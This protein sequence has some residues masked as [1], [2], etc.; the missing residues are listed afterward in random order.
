MKEAER[1][2]SEFGQAT[3][4]HLDALYGYALALCRNPATAEDLVQETYL[5]ATRGRQDI[6]PGNQMKSWLFTILRNAWFNELR[7]ARGGPTFIGLEPEDDSSFPAPEGT[8]P[9]ILLVR[10]IEREQVRTA[11]ANLPRHQREVIVLRD[12]EGFSYQQIAE[13]LGVPA[14][15]VM[16]RIGRAREHLRVVLGD[17]RSAKSAGY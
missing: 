9:F 13:I 14:G 17:A 10:K 7:H 4:D 3:L 2:K 11:I 12:L 5:R 16:S 6:E 15:T 1:A 8:D